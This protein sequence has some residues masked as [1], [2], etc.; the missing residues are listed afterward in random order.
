MENKISVDTDNQKTLALPREFA[1]DIGLKEGDSV[2]VVKD[3]KR[4]IVEKIE[5]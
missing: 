5:E 4:L 1:K 3:G 2:Q